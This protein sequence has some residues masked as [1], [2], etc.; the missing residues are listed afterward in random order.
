MVHLTHNNLREIGEKKSDS[1]V[2]HHID[3]QVPLYKS[4]LVTLQK[5]V[6]AYEF[7]KKLF[8]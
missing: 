6:N 3:F 8:L 7:R 5:Y 1:S 4:L 2:Y